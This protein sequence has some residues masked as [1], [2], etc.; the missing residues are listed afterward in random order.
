[1]NPAAEHPA[2]LDNRIDAGSEM[3]AID[4]AT[5]DLGRLARCGFG[6]VIYGEGKPARLIASTFAVDVCSGTKMTPV[7]PSLRIA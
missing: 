2:R 3:A 7:M 6:E 4:G 1:M 5:I